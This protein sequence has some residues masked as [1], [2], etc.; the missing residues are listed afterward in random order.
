M[1]GGW[2]ELSELLCGVVAY[3]YALIF[4]NLTLNI[5]LL[6]ASGV[7]YLQL[8]HLSSQPSFFLDNI[9]KMFQGSATYS[10]TNGK[11]IDA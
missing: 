7:G 1:S 9:T 2:E 8:I 3:V 5:G 11:F 10:C 4:P 6:S